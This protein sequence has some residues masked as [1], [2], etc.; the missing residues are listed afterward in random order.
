MFF[1]WSRLWAPVASEWEGP[2]DSDPYFTSGGTKAQGR[3]RRHSQSHSWSV[4]E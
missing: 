3:E 1:S 4:S 2:S